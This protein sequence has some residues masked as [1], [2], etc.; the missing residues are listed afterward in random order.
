[1]WRPVIP[2]VLIALTAACG[3]ELPTAQSVETHALAHSAPG[4]DT[5]LS[6]EARAELAQVRRATA[7]FHDV[8][9][10]M[11]AGYTVWSPNPFA[12]NATCPSNAEGQMGYHLVNVPLRG[13]ASDPVN[14]DAVL[15]LERPEMLLYEKRA[16]GKMHLVGWSTWS[17]RPRGRGYMGQARRP[18]RS[19]VSRFRR[20]RTASLRAVPRSRTTSCTSGS[21]SRTP[22]EC[23]TP[24]TH[25][26]PAEPV[27]R[28]WS[29]P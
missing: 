26:C 11:A 3:Q 19:S 18:R 14:G 25:A 23:S 15:D 17:S 9:K 4:G 10:A 8:D 28:T 21:G 7:R 24:G 29:S 20:A 12:P 27:V 16:D 13:A 1:M 2:T 6:A 5:R 22:S